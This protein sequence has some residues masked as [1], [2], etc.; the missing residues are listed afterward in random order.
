VAILLALELAKLAELGAANVWI[1]AD[2]AED[3]GSFATQPRRVPDTCRQACRHVSEPFKIRTSHRCNPDMHGIV[4]CLPLPVR[5]SIATRG[6]VQE[7]SFRWTA[8]L[9]IPVFTTAECC[10]QDY[11]VPRGATGLF[12]QLNESNPYFHTPVS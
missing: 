1:R 8:T 4:W 12:L 6:C 5:P 3:C 2:N 11:K 7:G 10:S 9:F